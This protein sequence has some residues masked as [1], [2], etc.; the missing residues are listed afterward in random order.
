[1]TAKA[2]ISVLQTRPGVAFRRLLMTRTTLWRKCDAFVQA[3]GLGP[4]SELGCD[5]LFAVRFCLFSVLPGRAR[6]QQQCL[7]FTMISIGGHKH[8]DEDRNSSRAV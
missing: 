3:R 8:T 6:W 1:M 5:L 2:S 4:F 7:R